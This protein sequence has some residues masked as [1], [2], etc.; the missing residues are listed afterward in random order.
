MGLRILF[1]LSFRQGGNES[2]RVQGLCCVFLVG[3][4]SPQVLSL[5]F[6][7]FCGILGVGERESTPCLVQGDLLG[8]FLAS[9]T[10]C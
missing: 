2:S 6:Y 7:K 10:L 4:P 1:H 8:R 3:V 9:L 5:F